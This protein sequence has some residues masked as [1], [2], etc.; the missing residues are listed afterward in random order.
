MAD[1]FVGSLRDIAKNVKR[2]HV[3]ARFDY[4]VSMIETGRWNPDGSPRCLDCEVGEPHV[5][6]VADREYRAALKIRDA[7]QA[8]IDDMEQRMEMVA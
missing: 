5:C 6:E 1:L 3:E 7:A 2:R 4:E 8:I